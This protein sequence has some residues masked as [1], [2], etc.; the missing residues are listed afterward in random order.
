ML[1]LILIFPP[2]LLYIIIVL[3]QGGTRDSDIY[4]LASVSWLHNLIFILF[5][6]ITVIKSN[7][8]ICLSV[9]LLLQRIVSFDWN[10]DHCVFSCDNS[11]SLIF[12][13]FKM[14]RRPAIPSDYK[15]RDR[16]NRILHDI[17]MMSASWGQSQC[18]AS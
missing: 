8:G 4:V 3:F 7:K 12:N 16:P 1:S 11:R 13:M 17:V 10:R 9:C 6:F 5:Y 18:V 14:L 15:N 2:M